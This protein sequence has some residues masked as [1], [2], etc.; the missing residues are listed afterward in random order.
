[1]AR[2]GECRVAP[3]GGSMSSVAVVTDTTHYLPRELVERNELHQVSL[4]VRWGD[5]LERESEMPD[6]DAFY[7]RLGTAR[8]LPTTSQPSIG[9]FVSVY[10][11]LLEAGRDIVS[12]HLA[13]GI[14]GTYDSALQAS[15]QL[16]E[17]GYEGRISVL[18]SSTA[19]GGFGFVALAAAAAARNGA[20]LN[21]AVAQARAAREQ[22]KIWFAVDTLEYLRRGGRIGKAQAWIG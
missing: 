12:I 5:S 9:D 1:M 6:F 8:E 10:E 14:S 15:R 7:A 20:G 21:E 3:R 19:C 4:Y 22:L 16:G 17:Q 2:G 13:A 18:D 11:Q